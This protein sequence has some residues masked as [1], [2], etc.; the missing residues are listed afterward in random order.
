MADIRRE[1]VVG[2]DTETRPA[3]RKGE[4][5]PPSLVQVATAGAVYL[6]PVQRLDCAAALAELLAA[7]GI[8]KAG[9]ALAHDLRQLGQVFPIAPQS[10]LDLGKVARRHGIEQTGLRNLAGL[11][12]GF[13]I[14]KGNRTSNWAAPRL[15]PAQIGYAATDAWAS[16]ELYL[17]FRQLG[18]IGEGRD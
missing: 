18:L 7:P 8:V 11:Y 5:Y 14:A 15:T 12:L 2:L 6:F 3:F 1:T 16:R 9:V 10:V 4:S 17:R 13:R